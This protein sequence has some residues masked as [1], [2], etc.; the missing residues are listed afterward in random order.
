MTSIELAATQHQTAPA[1]P[2]VWILSSGEDHEGGHILGVYA[3]KEAAKGPFV[4]AA[5]SIPFDLD[6]AWQDDD[7][8]VNV[9]G[10]CDWVSLE[11]HTV[12]AGPQIDA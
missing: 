5:A 8:S 9:H 12:I 11:P 7:G 6:A 4:Q 3:S 2:T 1:G 10:G